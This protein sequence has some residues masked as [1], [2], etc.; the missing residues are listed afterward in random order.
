[1]PQPPQPGLALALRLWS[2]GVGSG[3]VSPRLGQLLALLRA[4]LVR[5]HR[6]PQVGRVYFLP[7]LPRVAMSSVCLPV[8]LA[9][10]A[11]L[12]DVRGTGCGFRTRPRQPHTP[13]PSC[14]LGHRF[15][16]CDRRPGGSGD[17]RRAGAVC[18]QCCARA[19]WAEPP[20]CPG[21]FLGSGWAPESGSLEGWK[22]AVGPFPDDESAPCRTWLCLRLRPPSA[23]CTPLLGIPPLVR[24]VPPPSPQPLHW[25]QP[26]SDLPRSARVWWLCPG[27]PEP[28]SKAS[29]AWGP[30]GGSRT[31]SAPRISSATLVLLALPPLPR[32]LLRA[33]CVCASCGPSLFQARRPAVPAISSRSASSPQLTS[34]RQGHVL[35][36]QQ[37]RG[38]GVRD[39]RAEVES[40]SVVPS[41]GP[42]PS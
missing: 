14:L 11:V 8:S 15:P 5:A 18:A 32:A 22:A 39:S 28:A 21:G 3:P 31:E 24:P 29:A 10:G 34:L 12:E 7:P 1:M 42:S 6:V 19:Q 36:S 26:P 38:S 27:G 35:S 33:P 13:R 37:G 9:D 23:T 30:P 4:T 41:Q 2:W 16:I 17:E 40:G 25:L 20:P